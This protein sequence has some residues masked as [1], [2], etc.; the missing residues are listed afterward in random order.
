[1][2]NACIHKEQID[3][4][5]HIGTCTKCG[6][7][8]QYDWD[9]KRPPKIT[10]EG[11]VVAMAALETV[12]QPDSHIKPDNWRGWANRQK[13]GWYQAH[14]EQ[15]LADVETM[16]THKARQKWDICSATMSRLRKT[17]GVA[18]AAP[19]KEKAT[20]AGEFK[21][22]RPS[23]KGIYRSWGSVELAIDVDNLALNAR[24]LEWLM[25]LVRLFTEYPEDPKN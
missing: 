15:I 12:R 4:V 17:R 16:G 6:Q 11:G 10:K 24:E 25:G 19:A 22:I 2:S 7:V 21:G 14:K 13:H 1:M 23:I 18:P 20:S 9:W 8:R 3:R 5:T